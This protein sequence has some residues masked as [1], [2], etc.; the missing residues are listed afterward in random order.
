ME[1]S[2]KF[3]IY[4][5]KA[6]QEQIVRTFGCVRF[7][8]NYYLNKH[9]EVYDQTGETLNYYSYFRDVTQLK[10]QLTWLKEVDS[11]A[12]QSAL[13]NLDFAY[14]NFFRGLKQ[15]RSKYPQFKS[16]HCAKQSYKSVYV[17]DNIKVLDN[18]VQL[19]KLGI[20]KCRVTRKLEGRILSATVSQT[21]SGKFF[22][23]LCCTDIETSKHFNNDSAVGI[24]MGIK[25]FAVLSDGSVFENHKYLSA[26]LKK[27]TCLQRRLSRKTKG[28]KRYE[29]A[30]IKLAAL[31]EHITNQRKDMM[32]KV[33]SEIVRANKVICIE[34]L[35][36]QS[37]LKRHRVAQ[38]I[39]DSAWTEFRRQLKYKAEWYGGKVIEVDRF[40]P[41]SQ[42]CSVCGFKNTELKN[43]S[44]RKWIC[45]ECG[46]KHH[47]DHNAAVNILNEG[48]RQLA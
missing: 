36:T 2:Y 1:R 26:N 17:T 14:K 11:T 28:S 4:P 38:A 13:R 23:S 27:L 40:Y 20:V 21:A 18:S 19:P 22:V 30:R 6:Q 12:I 41:S 8:W 33:S 48:L 39:S 10:K 7:V 29:K 47:R 24:D 35:D 46:A 25:D 3:R 45:P 31:H 32:H 16:K 15:G 42:L 37:M 34:D 44:I 9:K 43:L 5:T